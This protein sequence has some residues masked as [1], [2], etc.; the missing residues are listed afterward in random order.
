MDCVRTAIRQGATSVKCL[1]RRDRA[2]MPGSQREVQNAEEEGVV[3][4]WLTSPQGFRG[5]NDIS[6]LTN[7]K[8]QSGDLKGVV[9]RKMRLGDPDAT[10]RRT[11]KRWMVLIILSKL[12]WLLKRWGLNRKIYPRCGINQN[13]QFR[14]GER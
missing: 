5:D 10:G 12:I 11:R 6:D 1:Y 9:V 2:N 13:F 4:E 14:A 7:F 3:F 8:D